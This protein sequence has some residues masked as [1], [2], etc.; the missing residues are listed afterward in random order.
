M[1]SMTKA[2]ANSSSESVNG[3][4]VFSGVGVRKRVGDGVKEE[5]IKAAFTPSFFLC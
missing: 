5:F 1:A 3:F 4:K 2:I